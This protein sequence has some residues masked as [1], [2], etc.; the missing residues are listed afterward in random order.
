MN[1]LTTASPHDAFIIDDEM[2]ICFLLSSVL[3]QM[4]ISAECAT[5]LHDAAIALKGKEP[6]IIFLDNYLPDGL[7]INFIKQ[8]KTEHPLSKIV[9]V[10]AHDTQAD[11]EKAINE[12]ADYF[13]GKP[14]SRDM[15]N[16]VIEACS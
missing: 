3:R 2:D 11:K 6:G 16:K 5:T 13:M 10:T 1:N 4:E 14:F 9:M 12:G 15:V 8:I 7:G